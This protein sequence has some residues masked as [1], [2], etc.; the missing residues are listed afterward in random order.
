VIKSIE[1]IEALLRRARRR[2]LA[3]KRPK[4]KVQRGAYARST[5]KPCK[6]KALANGRWV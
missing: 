6:A 4:V 2:R 3:A 1:K 5:G